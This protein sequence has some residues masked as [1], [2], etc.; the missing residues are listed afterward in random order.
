MLS[1]IAGVLLLVVPTAASA[2]EAADAVPFPSRTRF[3]AYS[4][5][6]PRPSSFYAQAGLMY[7]NNIFRLGEGVDPNGPRPGNRSDMVM[8]LGA[9]ATYDQRI[10]GRQNLF[11]TARG[12][13]FD[14]FDYND[15]DHFA[16]GLNGEWRS[17]WGNDL[18]TAFGAGRVRR[19]VDPSEIRRPVVNFITGDR[20]YGRGAYRL[21]ADWQVRAAGE[22]TTAERTGPTVD[23]LELEGRSATIGMD[24]ITPLGN[25][26]GVEFRRATGEA[27]VAP[28]VDPTF[29]ADAAQF[30]EREVAGTA[31]YVAG[32]SLR[33]LG[34]IGRTNR[35]YQNFGDR[36][37]TGTT[38]R[39]ALEYRPG[40][41]TIIDFEVYRS[42]QSIIDIAA[43]HVL[44]T[45]T[46]FGV[47]WAPTI[48]LVF[49]GRMLTERRQY[50]AP[51]SVVVGGAVDET[52]HIFRLGAGWEPRRF[53]ELSAGIE[54]GNRSTNI[55]FR[56][57]DY[58]Q[59]SINAATRF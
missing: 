45:G 48:K 59:L 11:L 14:F 24:Y 16:Y 1:R 39:S 27:T 38:Y 37:F 10:F 2:F 58:T 50:S 20:F 15:M 52:A 40:A 25:A 6:A 44:L 9:G 30:V 35:S 5:D 13:Y 18:T 7:D 43:S 42:P 33:F 36:D 17:E 41:K 46:A 29:G 8:R 12:E 22:F 49:S 3:P 51:A 26:F 4:V 55:A 21:L 28:E 32:T 54:Y 34:R 31:T 47:S 19:L 57:Y 23:E 56:D 53:I